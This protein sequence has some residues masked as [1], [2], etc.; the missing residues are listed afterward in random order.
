MPDLFSQLQARSEEEIFDLAEKLKKS[1][2]DYSMIEPLLIDAA[3]R[4]C[5]MLRVRYEAHMANGFD[6]AK[7]ILLVLGGK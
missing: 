1:N 6:E 5:K 3:M 4:E 2:R 7:A